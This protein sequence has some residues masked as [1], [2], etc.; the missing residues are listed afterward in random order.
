MPPGIS[1]RI[2]GG[3]S[4]GVTYEKCSTCAVVGMTV[5]QLPNGK[6][7]ARADIGRDDTGKRVRKSKVFSTKKEAQAA[8]RM[9]YELTRTDS[10]VAKNMRLDDF[11]AKIYLPDVTKRIRYTTLHK[12]KTD[13]NQRILP[14]LGHKLMGEIEHKDV[15]RMIDSCVS[16]KVAKT[17]R[18]IL[19]AI[20]NMAK[21]YGYLTANPATLNYRFPHR[22]IHPDQ[23]NGTWLSTFDQHEMLISQVDNPRYRLMCV[24][25]LGLGL[26][27]GEIFGL[28]W[29]DVD[30]D[31]RLVHVQ[32]TYVKEASGHELL[33]PKTYESNRYI[34]MRS[35]VYEYL[36]GEYESRKERN[37]AVLL[38]TIGLR[39]SPTGYAL[40]WVKYCKDK[41]LPN[42]TVLN[43]RHSFA[44]ACL[45]A[46]VDVTKVSKMLGHTSITTTVKRYVRFK[47][48]DI[49]DDFTRLG[50]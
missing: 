38:N 28:N 21:D 42:V 39:A 48:E 24:L 22:E 14:Q 20:L 19:R 10:L 7:R 40:K 32:R 36:L 37:G 11:I 34:P 49:A 43:M 13:I 3:Q 44:T 8:E 25:G 17:S 30:F 27:K 1:W 6:W 12:Y 2:T 26:R 18:D 9:W 45:N 33:P 35:F 47:P 29:E 23:H 31:R 4:H 41:G 16:Y 15:Q 46:G 5:S 50:I